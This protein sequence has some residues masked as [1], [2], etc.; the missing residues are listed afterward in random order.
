M[1]YLFFKKNIIKKL[2][3]FFICLFFVF[4]FSM[5][6]ASL[7]PESGSVGSSPSKGSKYATGD[8]ELNDALG[9]GIMV[10]DWI[11]LLVGSLALLFFVYGGVMFLISA[12]NEQRVTQAKTII[13]NAVIG[14]LIVFGSYIIIE[15]ALS[16]LGYKSNN[17]DESKI[18][19]NWNSPTFLN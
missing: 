17:L 15:F 16:G 10:V 19:G 3:L 12:G 8:Y 14:L 7:V 5:V 6:S 13:T 9:I 4:S 18:R 11:F 1:K 2:I